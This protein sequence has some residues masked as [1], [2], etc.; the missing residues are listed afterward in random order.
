[1]LQQ[2]SQVNVTTPQGENFYFHGADIPAKYDLL[3]WQ[4]TPEGTLKLAL[5]GRV[6]GLDVHLN[7]SA[8]E[9]STGTN[10]VVKRMFLMLENKQDDYYELPQLK[11]MVKL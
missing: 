4:T 9:W 6:D 8:I 10:Q 7:E 3:N 11:L 2:L 5:I 1:M